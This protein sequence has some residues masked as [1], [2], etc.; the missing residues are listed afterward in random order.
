MW[1]ASHKDSPEID[2]SRLMNRMSRGR[3]QP[4]TDIDM[5]LS[6]SEVFGVATNINLVCVVCPAFILATTFL[7][8]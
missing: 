8:F 5:T 2:S 4:F 6:L 3:P 7:G 1:V